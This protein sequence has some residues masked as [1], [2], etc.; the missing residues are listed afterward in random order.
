MVV[1]SLLVVV[2]VDTWVIGDGERSGEWGLEE[3]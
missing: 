2:V 3:I 1:A